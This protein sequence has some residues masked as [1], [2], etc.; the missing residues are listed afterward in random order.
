[1]IMDVDAITTCSS[2]VL[3]CQQSNTLG[4]GAGSGSTVTGMV[5]SGGEM[6]RAILLPLDYSGMKDPVDEA[7]YGETMLRNMDVQVGR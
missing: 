3:Y 2:P 1:M 4:F 5:R 6:H 7:A